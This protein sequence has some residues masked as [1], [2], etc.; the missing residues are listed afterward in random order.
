LKTDFTRTGKR[1]TLGL[2]NDGINAI[3]RY[4]VNN[5]Y[6]G[7]KQDALN[8]FLGYFRVKQTEGSPFARDTDFYRTSVVRI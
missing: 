8:L 6:D 4:I 1:T 5:F 3:Q 2:L 7:F